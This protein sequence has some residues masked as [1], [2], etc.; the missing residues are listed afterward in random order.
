MVEIGKTLG[1][2]REKNGQICET[3]YM[4]EKLLEIKQTHMTYVLATGRC[5]T[6]EK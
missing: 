1:G 2:N 4:G 6:K 3:A 5:L